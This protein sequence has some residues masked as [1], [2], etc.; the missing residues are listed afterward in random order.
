MAAPSPT[1]PATYPARAL[2]LPD[3]AAAGRIAAPSIGGEGPSAGAPS[4]TALWLT[5]PCF[6]PCPDAHPVTQPRRGSGSQALT[7]PGSAEASGG[8]VTPSVSGSKP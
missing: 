4:P 1:A 6:L 7:L 8:A 2:T 5:L 3:L